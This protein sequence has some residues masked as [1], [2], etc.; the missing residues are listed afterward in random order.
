VLPLP[1]TI[2]LPIQL[3]LKELKWVLFVAILGYMSYKIAQMDHFFYSQ[4][5]YFKSITLSDTGF[6][7][8]FSLLLSPVNCLFE[9][10]K[11][12][13]AAQ[14]HFSLSVAEA[15]RGVVT[16]QALN[17]VAPLNLGHISGRLLNLQKN[18]NAKWQAVGLVMVC[19]AAQFVV[20]LLAF[21]ASILFLGNDLS[22]FYQIDWRLIILCCLLVLVLFFPLFLH[23]QKQKW[24]QEAWQAFKELETPKLVKIFLYAALRYLTFSTQFVLM[25]YFLGVEKWWLELYMALSL[26]FMAKSLLPSFHFLSDLGVR[27]FAALLFLPVI[28]LAENIVVAGSLWVWIVNIFLPSVL[29]SFLLLRT[30]T[31][32]L[33]C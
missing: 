25:L 28:G 13:E 32:T 6:Y 21:F 7:F 24:F 14:K 2:S 1:T 23:L 8:L 31:N 11:W 29:G 10:L 22:L 5:L 17:L 19:Q 33:F 3:V 16:G 15:W 20:T 30:K 4:W 27:E 18:A 9:A 26:V 12:R